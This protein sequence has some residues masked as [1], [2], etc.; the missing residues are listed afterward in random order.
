LKQKK[1]NRRY[2]IKSAGLGILLAAGFLWDKLVKTE[3]LL[4]TKKKVVLPFNPNKTIDFQDDYIVVNKDG[5][6]KVFSSHCTHLGC[7][8]NKS[9]GNKLICPCHGSAFDTDGNAIKGPAVQPLSAK[10]FS[11]DKATNQ[12]MIEV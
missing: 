1:Q 9:A 7:N 3:N 10:A 4:T 12:I 11:I 6:T 2:F 5:I 8:I